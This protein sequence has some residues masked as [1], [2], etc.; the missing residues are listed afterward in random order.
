MSAKIKDK[1]IAGLNV[2]LLEH[3]HGHIE[4]G[5]PAKSSASSRARWQLIAAMIFCVFFMIAEVVGGYFAKSLAIM[6]E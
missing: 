4:G 5:K 2:G 1:D 6:T 3:G